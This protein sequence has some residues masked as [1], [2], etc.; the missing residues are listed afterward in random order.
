M[1]D[2]TCRG[3]KDHEYKLLPQAICLMYKNIIMYLYPEKTI[4]CFINGSFLNLQ[5]IT[6]DASFK[7]PKNIYDIENIFKKIET[8]SNFE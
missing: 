6:I 8:Y 1:F 2:D 4:Y 3:S 5:P 7:A